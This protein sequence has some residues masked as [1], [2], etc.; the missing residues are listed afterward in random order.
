M[1]MRLNGFSGTGIDIDDTVSKL[2]KAA[3]MPQDKL[4][5]KKQTLEW[6]RDEYRAMNSKIMDFRSAA[7]NMKLESSYLSKKAT[8]SAEHVLTATSTSVAAEG[9][10]KLEILNLAKA[11]QV[12]S[13]PPSGATSDSALIGLT[14]PANFTISG[15]TGSVTLNLK[16]TDTIASVVSQV[17][18]KTGVTGVS[19]NYDTNLKSFFFTSSSTGVTGDFTLKMEGDQTA[20]PGNPGD[21]LNKVFGLTSV[22]DPVTETSTLTI[23]GDKAKVMVNDDPN[24]V[25]YYDSNNFTFNGM[26]ITAKN[27]GVA[28]LTTTRDLDTT[29]NNIK[30]FVDKY[31]ELITTINSKMDEKRYK[32]FTPLTDEQRSEMK[33]D[34]IKAWEEKAKSGMLH[35]DDLLSSGINNM[36]TSFSTITQGLPIGTAKSLSEIGITTGNYMDKGKI[37]I[38]EAKLKKAIT[39]KPNEVMALFNADDKN[40]ASDLGDGLATRLYDRANA[41]MKTI[42][43][44]AGASSGIDLNS[45][46]GKNMSNIDTRI[47]SMT[48][49]LDTLQTRYYKQFT[50]ME[51]YI[52]Q[53]NA[54]SSSLAS[55]FS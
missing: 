31:N 9:T 29:F 32:G 38:D 16:A 55:Q 22:F 25:A 8:S 36:R 52:T 13:T 21:W 3:R 28:T 40:A 10:H 15:K 14:E 4:K 51:K 12:Y 46:I 17:N 26:N 47:N 45:V 49:R 23:T 53:L 20:D 5:Q 30:S 33:E 44:K 19:M 48:L 11:A 37:Y 24:M 6:Q 54:Q 50:A 43:S 35:N 41:L 7:F 39:E 18:A 42:T 27:L 1:V 2:M 34:Q